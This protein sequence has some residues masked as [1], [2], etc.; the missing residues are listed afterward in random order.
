MTEQRLFI[1]FSGGETSAYMARLL[2]TQWRNRWD[3]VVCAFANTAEE[4][5]QTLQFV[6]KCDE[7]FGLDVVWV[8][9]IVHPGQRKVTTHRV[10]SFE[11][12]SRAGE[13]YEAVIQKYG[14]PNK[15]FPHC[16]RELKLRPLQHL[17]ATIGWEPGTY[18]TAIGIR[19]DEPQRRS[20]NA[21]GARIIY[22]LLDWQPTTK[23]EVNQFWMAQ[24]FRLE[25]CGYQGNCKWCWKKSFRKLL[26]LMDDNPANFDF[27][28][29]MERQYGKI[30]AEFKKEVAPDYR[31]T[32]FRG[33]K[34]VTDLQVM[35][36]IAADVL[37]RAENDAIVLPNGERVS[38]DAEPDDGCVE[39]CEVDFA[40]MFD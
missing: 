38:L 14:I 17:M 4:N 26:T 39:T 12:A 3:K 31:R 25:L 8:E 20:P 6:K 23:P 27:P 30:G 16:T 34:S 1:S 18:D 7:A 29:R 33:N 37:D 2:T 11:T 36:A 15:K 22:P 21:E 24:P 35:Y 32:F 10:V 40:E 9:A 28:E 13:P 5:E 19:A